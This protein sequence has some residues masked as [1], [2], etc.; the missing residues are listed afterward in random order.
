MNF[1]LISFERLSNNLLAL[2]RNIFNLNQMAQNHDLRHNLNEF[3]FLDVNIK[4]LHAYLVMGAA[5]AVC[6]QTVS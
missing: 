4:I 3:E 6:T 5:L 2:V 1:Y